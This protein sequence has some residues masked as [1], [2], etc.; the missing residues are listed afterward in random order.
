MLT[1]TQEL[2]MI[3][4]RTLDPDTFLPCKVGDLLLAQ[5]RAQKMEDALR[6]IAKMKPEPVTPEFMQGP[7]VLFDACQR[8][9]RQALRKPKQK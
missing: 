7:K 3:D 8:I 4:M 6:E 2:D 5:D 1:P 9:A